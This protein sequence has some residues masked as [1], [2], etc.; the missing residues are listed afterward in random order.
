MNKRT[1]FLALLLTAMTSYTQTP[2]LP[3]AMH[4]YDFV[5]GRWQCH[6]VTPAGKVDYTFRQEVERP[7]D[8][9][10]FRFRTVSDKGSGMA[11][12]TYEPKAHLWR[13]FYFDD[14][15]PYSMGTA[16]D[17]I[18]NEQTWRGY[19]YNHGVRKS[20]GRVI[21]KKISDRER[22]GDFY[23]PLKS[24]KYRLVVSDICTKLQ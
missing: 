10:W 5:V 8:S 23:E 6:G 3:A 19:T 12:M 7:S 15:G 22:R 1:G 2:A 11:F 14:S 18:D 17:F 4:S 13:Y 20:W 9:H 21:V 24:G 16:P